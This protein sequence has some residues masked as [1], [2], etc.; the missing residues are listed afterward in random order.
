MTTQNTSMD[1][2]LEKNSPDFATVHAGEIV[3]G[4]VIAKDR[5]KLLVDIG[6][7]ATG[8]ISGRELTDTFQTAKDV[9][10]GD[11]ITAFVLE[12]ETDEGMIILS[13]RKAAQSRAWEYF[14]EIKQKGGTLEVIAREANKG[15]LMVEVNGVTAFLPVSQLA[16]QNYPR[17]DGA[18]A[19]EILSKLQELIGKKFTTKIILLTHTEETRKLVVSEREASAALREKEMTELKIGNKVKGHINGLV[20]FGAFMIFGN[21]EG[22]IHI[23]EIT[24]SHVK[25]PT[26]LFKI[27]DE[28][29]AEVIGIDGHKISLSLKRLQPDPWLDKIDSYPVN[30]IH[31]ATINKVTNF[32]VFVTLEEDVTGL[33]HVSEFEQE[34]ADPEKIYKEGDEVKVR[35]L[36]VLMEDHSLKLTFKGIDGGASKKAPAKKEEKAEKE[37][38]SEV[39]STTEEE[40]ETKEETEEKP[41]KKS[42]TNK[43]SAKKTTTKKEK[44]SSKEKKEKTEKKAPP[45]KAKSSSKKSTTKKKEK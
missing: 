26:E 1:E 29:E 3:T 30:S 27:G 39:T 17:V 22:L 31:T 5:G 9:K 11:E 37:K 12:D 44:S 43:T 10:I 40:K 20:K 15:G 21:L 23:S 18:N 7:V 24:H 34:G 33:V 2:L 8:I 25:S 42:T 45:K 38:D 19:E 14:E 32:G 13:L 4:L 35:I 41:K 36:E 16:P 6:G 28:V